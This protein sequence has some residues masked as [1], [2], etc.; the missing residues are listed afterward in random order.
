MTTTMTKDLDD[1]DGGNIALNW[2][3]EF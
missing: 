2:K 1:D 3:M